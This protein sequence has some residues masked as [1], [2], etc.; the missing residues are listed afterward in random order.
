LHLSLYGAIVSV[1]YS[2]VLRSLFWLIIYALVSYL[3][4]V[5]FVVNGCAKENTMINVQ[6]ILYYHAGV[7]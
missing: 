3:G 4:F 5:Q 2:F 6:Q 7:N 1:A